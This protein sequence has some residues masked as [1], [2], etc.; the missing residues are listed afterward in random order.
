M[1]ILSRCIDW[2]WRSPLPPSISGSSPDSGRDLFEAV[3]GDVVIGILSRLSIDQILRCCAV[4]KRWHSPLTATLHF[5]QLHRNNYKGSA[6]SGIMSHSWSHDKE[7]HDLGVLYLYRLR[8]Q[9]TQW[10]KEMLRFTQSST[11]DDVHSSAPC[12]PLLCASCN[13]LLVF[14]TI[15]G[16]QIHYIWNPVTHEQMTV[17]DMK[18]WFICVSESSTHPNH[19]VY[20]I[21]NLRGTSS[22]DISTSPYLPRGD[23]PALNVDDCLY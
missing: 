5:I 19:Y 23:M 6:T 13:G 16:Q 18:Y 22:Q 9:P 2:L 11:P 17:E 15:F 4:C 20:S 12:T 3:P 21:H 1:A 7:G 14:D 10:K 8:D